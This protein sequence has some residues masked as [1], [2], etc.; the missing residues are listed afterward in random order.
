MRESR[1]TSKTEGGHV[2]SMLI[3]SIHHILFISHLDEEAV[4]P[5]RDDTPS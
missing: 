5:P 4:D 1:V 3:V 2:L